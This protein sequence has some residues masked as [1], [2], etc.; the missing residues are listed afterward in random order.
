MKVYNLQHYFLGIILI[1]PPYADYGF[2]FWKYRN[3]EKSE[4]DDWKVST[5]SHGGGEHTEEIEKD[6]AME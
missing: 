4:R 2:K 3:S 6:L 5:G 1:H